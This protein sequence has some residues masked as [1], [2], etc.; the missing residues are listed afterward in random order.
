MGRAP[1]SIALLAAAAGLWLA[2]AAPAFDAKKM[3]DH[4][5]DPAAIRKAQAD[6]DAEHGAEHDAGHGHEAPK[7]RGEE[8]SIDVLRVDAVLF[9]WTV[10]LFLGLLFL[11]NKIAWQPMLRALDDRDDRIASALRE[12][13][14]AQ[15]DARKQ[16]EAQEAELA[17]IHAE[18]R[19]AVEDARAAAQREG[20]QI[21]AQSRAAA[22]A[23]RAK[24]L[25]EI[26]AARV[27][28]LA[29]V[30]GTVADLSAQIA[31]RVLNRKVDAG[32]AQAA[33]QE[34]RG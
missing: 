16:F 11:L 29:S 30:E 7:L 33:M 17:R 13:E 34:G 18:S 26:E 31:E 20:D 24:A 23:D 9:V 8:Q 27:E 28:A 3:G 22:D 6:R 1:T 32:A 2:A 4:E 15:E 10:V 25:A 19:K 12:A 14:A 5:P 21:L